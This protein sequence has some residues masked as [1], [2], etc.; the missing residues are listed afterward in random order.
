MY[1]ANGYHRIKQ[2]YVFNN[3]FFQAGEIFFVSKLFGE[4]DALYTCM[5]Y[6]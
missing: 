1:S 6:G 2:P 4:A 3:G 5:P